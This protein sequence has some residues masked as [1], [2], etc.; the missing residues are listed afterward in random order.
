[1]LKQNQHINGL[2]FI[3]DHHFAEDHFTLDAL[4]S[5]S[6]LPVTFRVQPGTSGQIRLNGGNLVTMLAAGKA[7][8]IAEQSGNEIYTAADPVSATFC[9]L[10]EAPVLRQAIVSGETILTSSVPTNVWILNSKVIDFTGQ[11]YTVHEP[12]N[13]QVIANFDGCIDGYSNTVTVGDIT[14]LEDEPLT[15]I[16]L[17]PNPTEKNVTIRYQSPSQIRVIDMRGKELIN[18]TTGGGESVFDVSSFAAGVYVV[19]INDHRTTHH[20]KFI[21]R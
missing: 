9:V 3:T 18:Q 11:S 5:T 8:I 2:F 1:V 6:G 15:G 7:T 20:V 10:P 16:Q 19:I 13:Y 17:Y 14:G 21:K 12:G 4:T